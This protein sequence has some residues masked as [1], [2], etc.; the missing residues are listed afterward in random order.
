MLA[1]YASAPSENSAMLAD[2]RVLEAWQLE[3]QAYSSGT[4][5]DF[6]ATATALAAASQVYPEEAVLHR[7][8]GY[9]YLEKLAS[10]A[11]A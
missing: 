10:P 11:A 8:L 1:T 7:S 2:P 5:R 6:R 4:E 9:L 3:Q